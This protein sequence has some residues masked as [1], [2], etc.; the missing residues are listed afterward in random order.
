M[1]NK[2][3]LVGLLSLSLIGLFAQSTGRVRTYLVTATD[4]D[5]PVRVGTN[6]YTAFTYVFTGVKGARTNNTSTVWI[7]FIPTNSVS[8]N[9]V[10]G[11]PLEPGQIISITENR[12]GLP[13]NLFW[14]DTETVGD[15]ASIIAIE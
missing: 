4:V 15:G 3:I 5:V 6:G 8:T 1:K 9:L 14:I 7:Q 11:I 12:K 10:G 2:L 13:D